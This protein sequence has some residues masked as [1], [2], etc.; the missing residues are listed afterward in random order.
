M[1]LSLTLA[2]NASMAVLALA[3]AIPLAGCDD[4]PG[5]Q[6]GDGGSQVIDGSID[7]DAP[8]IGLQCRQI[9]C[10]GGGTTSISGYVTTPK[11][12]LELYNVI[13]YVPQTPLTP[14]ASGASCE[15]C[16]ATLSGNPLVQT[17]TDTAGHFV[18]ENM[19]VG[20]GLSLVIQVGKWR[21]LV[22]LPTLSE[23]VDT[24][25]ESE[26]TRLPKNQSEGDIPKIALVTGGQDALECLLLKVGLDPVEFTPE[27]GSGRVNF[28]DSADG[29]AKYTAAMN[30]GAQFSDATALWDTLA[31][32]LPY[33]ILL[34]SCD[35]KENPTNKS[36]AARQAMYDFTSMGG[37]VFASHWHNFFIEAG[38]DPLPT[39]ATFNHQADLNSI[40]ADIDM[41]FEKGAALATWLMNVEGSTVLGKIALTA[42]QH[43][44][45]AVN[46]AF[47]QRW[48]YTTS[49]ASVQYLSFNTPL[50]VDPEDQCGRTVV[51]DIHVSSGDDPGEDFPSGCTTTSLS[52]QEKALIYMLFDLSACIAPDVIIE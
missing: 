40:T 6:N 47:A 11:G 38:P 43:T 16:S 48:I 30:G 31:G 39:V 9:V 20:Q 3:I 34:L 51:S 33:D 15:Q 25:L 8:C 1:H 36:V 27:A 17:T 50:G 35:G 19:P 23:C 41:T 21:R 12:D 18:L 49:P 22:P 4:P 24:V 52:P 46:P 5:N 2:R 26:L 10:P 28:F 7:G 29:S 14:F 42:A 13:V 45:D 44:I 37:R 32:M